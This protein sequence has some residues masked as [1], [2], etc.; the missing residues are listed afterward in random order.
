VHLPI[1]W[2]KYSVNKNGKEIFKEGKQVG[3]ETDVKFVQQKGDRL[4]FT[5]NSGN[6][7]FTIKMC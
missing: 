4:V 6:Y 3:K 1:L 7:E 5:V 2:E